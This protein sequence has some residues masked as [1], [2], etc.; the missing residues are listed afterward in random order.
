MKKQ[1]ISEK[2]SVLLA[3]CD[4]EQLPELEEYLSEHNLKNGMIFMGKGTAESDI[5]DIFGFGMNDKIITALLVRESQQDKIIKEITKLLRI[6]EDQF[7]LTML[8][9][10]SSASNVVLDMLGIEIL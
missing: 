2:F 1:T 4:N 8:L 6:E 5:A 3:I 9:E 7:G 10:T